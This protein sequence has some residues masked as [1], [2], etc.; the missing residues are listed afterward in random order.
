MTRDYSKLAIAAVLF[1][2]LIFVVVQIVK[3]SGRMRAAKGMYDS[4]Q[5]DF[6]R[7]RA[8]HENLKAEFSYF[9]NPVNLSKELRS[10]FNY[11]L[12]GEKILILVQEESAP[13]STESRR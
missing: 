6:E 4:V 5:T 7:T 11:T 3:F 8:D 10:R 9:S 2:L 1:I 12:P 13:T